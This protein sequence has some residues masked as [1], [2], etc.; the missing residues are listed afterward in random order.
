MTA[1]LNRPLPELLGRKDTQSYGEWLVENCPPTRGVPGTSVESRIMR[2][3]MANDP[4]SVAIRA[5]EMVHAKVSPNADDMVKWLSRGRASKESLVA[6]EEMRVNHL[7][8]LAGFDLSV[9]A[10]GSEE[11]AGERTVALNDW[12][13]AVQFAISTVGTGSH[14]K[15]LTGIRRHNRTWATVLAD[16]AKRAH[17]EMKKATKH[18]TAELASTDKY[19]GLGPI[20]YSFTERLAEWIDRLSETPPKEKAPEETPG[21]SSDEGEST[22][23]KA[24]S[25]APKKRGRKPVDES[26][27]DEADS[28]VDESRRVTPVGHGGYGDVIDW[29][30]LKVEKCPMPTVLSGNM[31]KKRVASNT[32]KSPRRMHR[33]LTDPERRVF[34]RVIRGKGGVVVFDGSGSMRVTPSE[35]KRVVEAAPGAT[36]FVYTMVDS[37][38]DSDGVPVQPNCWMLAHKGRM[39]DEMPYKRGAGNGVDLPALRHA[40]EYRHRSTTPFVW[41]SDGMVTGKHDS[42]SDSLAMD[43]MKYVM[44][45]NI[46]VAPDV[47]SAIVML[48]K[49]TKGEAVKTQWSEHMRYLWKQSGG[50]LS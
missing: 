32:G 3:P 17:K 31:G 19:E 41:V 28:A 21:K 44:K 12:T 15:F 14:K 37:K 34:D 1:T 4:L 16:I 39:V 22:E 10:D 30:P 2:A 29:F 45:N 7:A 40:M 43:T 36:V 48:N 27:K 26:A 33:L 11:A 25:D 13:F 42:Y 47:E 18:G 49:L 20:G 35:V 6:C 8:S 23:T 9:L 46:L 38:L 24:D 50:V 5:H